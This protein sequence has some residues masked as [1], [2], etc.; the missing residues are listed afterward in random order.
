[1]AD[2]SRTGVVPRQPE[3]GAGT[4]PEAGDLPARQEAERR[5]VTVL[6]CDVVGSAALSGLLDPEDLRD[7][8]RAY[9]AAAEEI[10]TAYEGY[11]AQYLG[12]GLLVYFGYPRAHEDDAARAVRTAL[13]IIRQ[14]EQLSAQLQEQGR[15]PLAVRIG[16][17]TGLVVVGAMGSGGRQERLAVG[18]T[19]N[20][21]AWLQGLAEPG[22]AA[23]SGATQRLV[24][25]LF[26][27]RDLGARTVRGFAGPVTVYQVVE[28]RPMRSR[29]ELAAV[30]GLTTLVG[31]D[32]EVGLMLD[33]WERSREGAGQV[34]LLSGEPGIGKSRLAQVLRDR[35]GA[36][37]HS[38]VEC[39][40]SPYYTNS[41]LYPLIDLL[42]RLAGL[43]PEEVA[44]RKL[45]KLEGFLEHRGFTLP[46]PAP[47]FASLLSIPDGS[48][49]GPLDLSPDEQ[50]RQTL[51]ALLEVL[52]RAEADLP[53]ILVVEDLHWADPSTVELLGPLVDRVATA[54][55]LVL[56]TYRPEFTPPWP[57]RG[58]MTQLG[59]SRLTPTQAEVMVE[60]VAVGRLS[61]AVCRQVVAA[62]DGVP[63]FTE[64]MTKAVLEE[65]LVTA[66]ASFAGTA[67]Q[68]VGSIPVTLNDSLMARLDRLGTGKDVAQL[69]AVLGREFPHELIQAVSPWSEGTLV[70]GLA[71]LVDA[72]LLYARGVAPQVTYLFK[73]ALI[74]EAAYQSLLKATRR[75]YHGEV[76]ETLVERFPDT[77]EARPEL[78]AHHL[79]EAGHTEEAVAQWMK[80]GLRAVERSAYPEAIA[81]LSRGLELLETLPDSPAR[82][83]EEMN[84]QTDLARALEVVRGWA[85]PEVG[86]AYNRA[87]ELARAVGGTP[88]LFSALHG[89]WEFHELRGEMAVLLEEAGRLRDLAE[90]NGDPLLRMEAQHALGES[91]MYQAKYSAAVREF[92]QS[93]EIYD[94]V[95]HHP[96]AIQSGDYDHNVAAH[97]LSAWSLWILGYPDRALAR[98]E[99]AITLADE[100]AH[101]Y[102]Q[103]FALTFAA[104]QRQFRR[105]APECEERAEA[106]LSLSLQVEVPIFIAGCR[107]LRG[108]ATAQRGEANQSIGEIAQALADW[109]EIGT[110][111]LRPGWLSLLAESYGLAR[112][113]E[114]GLAALEEAITEVD[115]RGE[116]W[117]QAEL[118]RLQGSL[119]MLLPAPDPASAET[120]FLRAIDIAR[121]QEARSLE[122]RAAV[123]LGR[124][125]QQ[126]GKA[127]E[128]R[129]LLEP[130]YEWFTEGF[131]TPD[132]QEARALLAAVS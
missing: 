69:G 100:L 64:E 106:G 104:W 9:Q 73:H 115:R 121:Q 119:I 128:A 22:T 62:T 39:R 18:E 123:S 49:Y 103:V 19:P 32:H 16:V 113:P 81:H 45:D 51:D 74:Q 44:E 130:V 101:P 60:Q 122:L 28:E 108:W 8:M 6:F 124:L 93:M 61:T 67:S 131:E 109:R 47:L 13:G 80:A 89:L 111:L 57:I 23:I 87:L 97:A 40:C 33:R 92:E 76:A 48:R 58:Y 114:R 77:A 25:G 7:V 17:H 75:K 53:A 95:R 10:I 3:P 71:Q 12:D 14:T 72:E 63:L 37:P 56:F 15:P 99:R 2:G 85:A 43:D 20:L 31:R 79:T 86:S 88:D 110:E 96:L 52:L 55:M 107:F 26:E 84:L 83:R 46:G 90:T 132:L 30:T 1:L 112:Q 78:L 116:I 5:Q 29:L 59:V 65:N 66:G 70:Q 129:A 91:L 50:R 35:T 126:Q 98:A 68:V 11:I 4:R 94:P 24:Q 41:A 127:E 36:E 118:Y 34:L 82:S 102:S 54:R 105:E 125:W 27:L 21:A 42:Q 117:S 38:S 120:C